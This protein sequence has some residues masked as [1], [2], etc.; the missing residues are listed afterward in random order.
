MIHV[1]VHVMHQDFR[2]SLTGVYLLHIIFSENHH[3]KVQ[4]LSLLT[5]L[6]F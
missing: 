2:F 5:N 6:T 4:F 3:L 1:L